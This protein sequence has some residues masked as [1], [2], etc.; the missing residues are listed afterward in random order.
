M[1]HGVRSQL[2]ELGARDLRKAFA[3]G[4]S[5]HFAASQQ[6]GRFLSEADINRGDHTTGFV[7]TCLSHR[8]PPKM[9][10][11]SG[12]RSWRALIEEKRKGMPV[13]PAAASAALAQAQGN[14]VASAASGRGPLFQRHRRRDAPAWPPEGPAV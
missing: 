11:K 4:P 9:R 12:R 2:I 10:L 5:R 7:S 8:V 3:F 6:F 1:R 13:R 14:L